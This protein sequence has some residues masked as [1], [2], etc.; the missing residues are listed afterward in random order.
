MAHKNQK[1]VPVEGPTM[2]SK[3]GQ[4]LPEQY[5]KPVGKKPTVGFA[6]GVGPKKMRKGRGQ[7]AAAVNPLGKGRGGK[8]QAGAKLDD[9]EVYNMNQA[10][11]DTLQAKVLNKK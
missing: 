1:S 10:D 11:F 6:R 9:S 8:P 2:L 5:G 7:S 3:A 4:P